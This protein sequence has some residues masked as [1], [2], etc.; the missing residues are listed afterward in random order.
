MSN[1]EFGGPRNPD[2]GGPPGTN[3]PRYPREEGRTGWAWIASAAGIIIVLLLVFSFSNGMWTNSTSPT[4]SNPPA[5]TTGQGG[6][7]VNPGPAR[8]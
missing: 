3:P 1:P 4:A 7:N 5:T 2:F 6:T 8:P